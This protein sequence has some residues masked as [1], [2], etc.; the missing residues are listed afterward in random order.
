MNLVDHLFIFLLFV[1]QPIHGAWAYR[2]FI[3]KIEAGEPADRMKVY[4]EMMIVEWI[5]LAVL[6]LA[7]VFFGRSASDL[8]FVSPG[9]AGFWI[10]T[11]LLALAIGFLAYSW[12]AART[13]SSEDKAT[14]AAAMGKLVHVLPHTDGELRSFY[15]VSVTAG[16][17]EEIIY[18]GFAFWYLSAFM[19]IW[20]VVLV[21]S[22]A[23]G[24]G[25]SYQGSSGIVRVT[26]IGIVFGALYV[27]TGSIWLP[28]VAHIL[29]DAL[30]GASIVEILKDESPEPAAAP[31][32]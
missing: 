15:K 17:V 9:G 19:P 14:Q 4:R 1:V 11:A 28:I 6:A 2:N 13:M 7:W 24:L 27:V 30:Q 32:A 25:H 21:S 3:R 23:F 16:I 22:L 20:A 29:L 5:A 26:L 8:G 12:Q 18:R 31:G 10:G